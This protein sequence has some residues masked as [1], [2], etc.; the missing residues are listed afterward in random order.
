MTTKQLQLSSGRNIEYTVSGSQDGLPLIWCHG[1][2]NSAK[3]MPDLLKAC[4]KKNLS[5]ITYSRAGY[6]GTSRNKGRQV[7]DDVADVQA[8]L[9]HLGHKRCLVGGWSGGGP[10][11]LACAARLPACAAAAVFAGVAPY[12]AEG[13]DFLADIE[14]YQLALKGETDIDAF[15]AKS[16]WGILQIDAADLTTLMS[17]FLPSV[18]QKALTGSKDFGSYNVASMREGLKHNADGWVDDDL[19]FLKP[20]GFDLAEIKRPVLLYQGGKDVMVPDAHGKWLGS[21][22]TS[23]TTHFEPAEGHFSILFGRIESMLDDL[24]A[25]AA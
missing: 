16:R 22:L 11:A 3:P 23:A 6:G 13:L 5:L 8:L 1:T 21:H 14:E 15:C 17:S 20:W 4:E 24:I 2:P 25:A 18:D 9:D 19:A 10:H 7:V 12:D